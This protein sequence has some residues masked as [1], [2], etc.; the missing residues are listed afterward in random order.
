[1]TRSSPAD[2]G[3]GRE[4][5]LPSLTPSR[6]QLYSGCRGRTKLYFQRVETVPSLADGTDAII[7]SLEPT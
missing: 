7:G 2:L 1:M 4:R 5:P 6:T 3:D